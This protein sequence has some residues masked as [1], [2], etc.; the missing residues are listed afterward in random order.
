MDR[1]SHLNMTDDYTKSRI[2]LRDM[3]ERT[4]R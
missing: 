1:I 2:L 4:L 3:K